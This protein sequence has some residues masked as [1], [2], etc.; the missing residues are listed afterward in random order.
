MASSQD[1]LSASAFGQNGSVLINSTNAVSPKPGAHF[2]AITFITNTVFANT[3]DGL[4]SNT[5]DHAVMTSTT[6]AFTDVAMS[7]NSTNG[8]QLG[9]NGSS[10]NGIT[11]PAGITVYG[12][13][14]KITLASGTAVA[15]LHNTPD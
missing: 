9:L 3:A 6:S 8:G 4:V 14:S 7:F 5:S 15:Y 12:K 1:Y 13:W 2:N 10:T 11:F